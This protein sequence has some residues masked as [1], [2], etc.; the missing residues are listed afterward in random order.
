MIERVPLLRSIAH[1]IV[2]EENALFHLPPGDRR[3]PSDLTLVSKDALFD[4]LCEMGYPLAAQNHRAQCNFYAHC[5]IIGV[6][7]GRIVSASY[8]KDD[9]GILDWLRNEDEAVEKVKD[10]PMFK[11]ILGAP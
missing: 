11:K 5:D 7:T 8:P 9:Q 10:D 4:L 6:L 3:V 2:E 1:T